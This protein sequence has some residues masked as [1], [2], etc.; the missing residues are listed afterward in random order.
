KDQDLP[1]DPMK[2]SGVCGRLQ[3]CLAY[4]NTQ[5]REAKSRMP[6]KGQAVE[7][8]SGNGVIVGI[9]PFKESVVVEFESQAN[10]EFPLSQIKVKETTQPAETVNGANGEEKADPV[11]AET[12]QDETNTQKGKK[13]DGPG[14]DSP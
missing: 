1:L 9:F 6:R 5:Y 11:I 7:T 3:C 13:T 8:P 14:A 10:A 2:I 4:E 12:L